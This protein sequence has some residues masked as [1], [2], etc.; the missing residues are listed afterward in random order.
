MILS[1]AMKELVALMKSTGLPYEIREGKKHFKLYVG[2]KCAA[3]VSRGDRP[4][5][6]MRGM[7]NIVAAVKRAARQCMNEKG[8]PA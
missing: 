6:G 5:Q 3:V 2:G 1:P 7:K 8:Q 4:G